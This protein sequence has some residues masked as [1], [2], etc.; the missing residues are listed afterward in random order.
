MRTYNIIIK[1]FTSYFLSVPLLQHIV[2]QITKSLASFVCPSVCLSVCP[3][4]LLRSQFLFDIDEILHSR[5]GPE[6]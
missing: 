6:K 1:I 5:L 2:G 4:A 3:S